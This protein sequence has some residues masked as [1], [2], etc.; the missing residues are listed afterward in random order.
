VNRE[1]ATDG[2]ELGRVVALLRDNVQAGHANFC[3]VHDNYRFLIRF[4]QSGRGIEIEK[5]GREISVRSV[6]SVESRRQRYDLVYTTRV[7]YLLGS[8]A[9]E[10]G[11]ETLY[12]GSGGCSSTRTSPWCPE[13][14]TAS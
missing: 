4:R 6:N 3:H 12:V 5:R 8:L 13:T 10:Y 1:V 2:A 14:C 9:T 7:A 11:H